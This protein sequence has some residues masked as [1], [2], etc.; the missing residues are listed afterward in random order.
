MKTLRDLI[1]H[2]QDPDELREL[3][4]E[5]NRLCAPKNLKPRK[6]R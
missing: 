5:A 3:V 6:I 4:E 1:L 2:E